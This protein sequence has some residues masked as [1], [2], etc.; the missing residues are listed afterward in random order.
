MD[1]SYPRTP[2]TYHKF[3]VGH[4]NSH[5]ILVIHLHLTNNISAYDCHKRFIF[6]RRTVPYT[7]VPER[8]KY[9]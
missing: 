6:L 2:Y 8:N 5:D 1:N 4:L 9:S 7:V 3:L